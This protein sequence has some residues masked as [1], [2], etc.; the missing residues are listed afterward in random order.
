MK[1]TNY[2]FIAQNLGEKKL[3]VININNVSGET[4]SYIVNIPKKEKFVCFVDFNQFEDIGFYP[5][6]LRIECCSF[7]LYMTTDTR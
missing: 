7:F 5:K 2:P 4:K 3:E 1:S 6:N